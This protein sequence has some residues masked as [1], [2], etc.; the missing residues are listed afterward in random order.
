MIVFLF[1][2]Q[3]IIIV[4]T[5]AFVQVRKT[6]ILKDFFKFHSNVGLK[7]IVIL[8]VFKYSAILKYVHVLCYFGKLV[9]EI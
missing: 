2:S 3:A 9:L 7:L 6:C 5:V 4:V 1:F 8:T